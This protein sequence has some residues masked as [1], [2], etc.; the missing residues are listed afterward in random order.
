[1]SVVILVSEFIFRL[2]P[3]HTTGGRSRGHRRWVKLHCPSTTVRFYKQACG[4]V[5]KCPIPCACY[6]NFNMFQI[7]ASEFGTM[8]MCRQMRAW[9]DEFV[10][11]VTE[12]MVHGVCKV[13]AQPSFSVIQ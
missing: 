1:M 7:S 2:S 12:G 11:M 9:A 6:G 5:V 10:V 13:V 3:I 8:D 4:T